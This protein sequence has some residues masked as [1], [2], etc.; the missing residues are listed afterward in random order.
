[1]L[2]ASYAGEI[3]FDFRMN[4]D[5]VVFSQW[6]GFDAV[7]I[8]GGVSVFQEGEPLLEG[9]PYRFVLPQGTEITNI[10]VEII[11]N[12]KL[13]GSRDIPP[14]IYSILSQPIPV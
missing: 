1:M 9:I 12:I 13:D 2:S 14:V 8:P 11:E 10:S 4:P 6:Q 7:S 5:D 3:T